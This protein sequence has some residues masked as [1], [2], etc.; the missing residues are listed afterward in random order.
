MTSEPVIGVDGCRGGW[1]AVERRGD[2]TVDAQLLTDLAS[3]LRRVRCGKV[4]AL[5]IDMPIGLLDQQPRSCDV[6][7]R[8]L[9]GPRRSS[10]FPAPV[11]DALAAE[12]YEDACRR[13]RSVSGKALSKQAFNLVPKIAEVDRLITPGDQDRVVEAHPECAFVRLAGTPLESAKR[14]A[15]GQRLRERLLDGVDPALG[16]LVRAERERGALPILDVIDAAVL[17]VTADH[18]ATGTERRL[19]TDIDPR[20]LRAEI[21]Y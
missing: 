17:T 21:A 3:L 15:E 6:E 16:R 5:A 9:L 12:D 18:V 7:A 19:G 14:T 10:V 20:G 4:A 11:R 8:R 1:L 2:G 13:S